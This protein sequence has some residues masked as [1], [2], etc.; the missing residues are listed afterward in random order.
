MS[1]LVALSARSFYPLIDCA[2]TTA[3]LSY[4]T[5]K[6]GCRSK[7]KSLDLSCN[8]LTNWTRHLD[9]LALNNGVS[10]WNGTNDQQL[11][12]PIN[13]CHRVNVG[14]ITLSTLLL[15]V[16]VLPMNKLGSSAIS[17]G[18]ALGTPAVA[19]ITGLSWNSTSNLIQVQIELPLDSDTNELANCACHL[20]ESVLDYGR[21]CGITTSTS[22]SLR[23]ITFNC[24]GLRT[25]DF[26]DFSTYCHGLAY[27][28][29]IRFVGDFT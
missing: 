16:T 25:D 17:S 3:V 14:L 11:F 2:I 18:G 5:S 29:G 21:S 24:E 27:E 1:R 28:V 12:T 10:C 20:D 7:S 13:F 19:M 22:G 8:E 4:S 26:F 23:P 15:T 6:S 9:S